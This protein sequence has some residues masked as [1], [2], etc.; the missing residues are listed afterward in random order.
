MTNH[1]R[2]HFVRFD[3]VFSTLVRFCSLH[4]YC[5]RPFSH[6]HSSK[7]GIYF[8]AGLFEGNWWDGGGGSSGNDNIPSTK[9]PNSPKAPSNNGTT[10]PVSIMLSWN[11]PYGNTFSL[12]LCVCVF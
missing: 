3:V 6:D 5:N 2:T 7:K 8:I 10:T 4:T 9:A 1:H 11:V 12:L